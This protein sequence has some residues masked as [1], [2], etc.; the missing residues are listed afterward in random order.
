MRKIQIEA[1]FNR[2]GIFG[3]VE[4]NG[5]ICLVQYFSILIFAYKQYRRRLREKRGGLEW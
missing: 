4:L 5:L 3:Y 1:D 2:A